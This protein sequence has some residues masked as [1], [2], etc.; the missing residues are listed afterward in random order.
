[1]FTE[2]EPGRGLAPE[3]GTGTGLDQQ[4]QQQQE[5]A[6]GLRFSPCQPGMREAVFDSTEC[7]SGGSST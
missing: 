5:G 4:Q 7:P 2:P 1:V 6:I 3:L